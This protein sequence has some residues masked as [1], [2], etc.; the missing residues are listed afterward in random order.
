MWMEENQ[1]HQQYSC[2]LCSTVPIQY[3]LLML[4]ALG[5]EKKDQL[6]NRMYTAWL[7]FLCNIYSYVVV[8][9]LWLAVEWYTG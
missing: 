6:L 5:G 1:V 2:S 3:V 4:T 9:N 8:S 7:S